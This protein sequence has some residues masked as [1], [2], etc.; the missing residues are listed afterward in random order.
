VRTSRSLR[1]AL[2][3]SAFAAAP[4]LAGP[5][6]PSKPS[7]LV[8][9]RAVSTPCPTV[10]P[11]EITPYAIDQMTTID[12]LQVPFVIPPKQV[13]VITHVH[14]AASGATANAE[15]GIFLISVVGMDGGVLTE[16][17]VHTSASGRGSTNI[18][19]PTG[20]AVRPGTTICATTTD[21]AAF[22]S[23]TG[24]FAKDK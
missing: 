19:L 2:L 24:F 17:T 4:S 13:F 1:V 8:S 10:H 9:A 20:I 5:L 21:G 6:A 12:G 11:V 14:L 22:G 18:D 15:V 16:G 7:Q 23:V 3:A